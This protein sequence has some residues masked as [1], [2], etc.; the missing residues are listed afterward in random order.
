MDRITSIALLTGL[1]AALGACAAGPLGP[2]EPNRSVYSLNQPVV[3]RSEF[4]MDLASS[5]AGLSP[6]ERERL[7][8][9]FGSLGLG[10]GDHVW[11]EDPTGADKPRDDIA[12]VA[13]EYG[14]L[15]EDGAPVTSGTVHPGSARV[16][17][18]RSSAHVPSC[19]NWSDPGGPSAT[20]S[21]Y[22]CAMNSNLAAMIA[23]PTDLVLGEAGSG[24]ADAQA[25]SKAIRVYRE[26]KPTGADGL[27]SIK[28]RGGN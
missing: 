11:V 16:V 25:S 14:I 23:D 5:P 1:T 19:P 17:V 26:S 24:T 7:D 28:T 18:S 20:S 27:Q 4:V 2:V 8:A 3:Q 6:Q 12:R 10:Y 13:A 15:L 22:G 21:N 9:W